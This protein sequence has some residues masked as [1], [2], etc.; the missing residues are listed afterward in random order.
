LGAAFGA[1]FGAALGGAAGAPG[2]GWGCWAW[3]P[4]A[5]NEADNAV[6]TNRAVTR[7]RG[8]TGAAKI[9]KFIAEN[10]F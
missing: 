5:S 8:H 10:P 7:P 1:V 6:A 9:R 2:A 4:E 3:V